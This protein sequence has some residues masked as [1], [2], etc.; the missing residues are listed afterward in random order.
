[1]V[2]S[3][4]EITRQLGYRAGSYFVKETIRPKYAIPSREESGVFIHEN[5]EGIIPR[6]KADESLLAEIV[7]RKF[8]D[9][10]PLYRVSEIFSRDNVQITRQ[11]HSTFLN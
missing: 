2:T 6:S 10:Q 4:E 8:A 1:M 5:S 7:T 11:L 9:H 3:G